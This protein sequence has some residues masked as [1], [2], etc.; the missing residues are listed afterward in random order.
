MGSWSSPWILVLDRFYR[1]YGCRLNELLQI[2]RGAA[3]NVWF[4]QDTDG[5]DERARDRRR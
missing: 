4:L 1:Q 3:V 2:E 5:S